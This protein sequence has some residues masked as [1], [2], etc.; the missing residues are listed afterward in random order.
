[1]VLLCCLCSFAAGGGGSD[2]PVIV[3]QVLAAVDAMPLLRSDVD[4]ILMLDLLSPEEG[5]SHDELVA[6]A[7]QHRINLELGYRELERSGVLYRL[8]QDVDGVVQ[9]MTAAITASGN[10]ETKLSAK[11]LSWEDVRVLAVRIAAVNAFIDE[12][13]RSQITVTQPE[14]EQEYQRLVRETAGDPGS[15]PEQREQLSRLLV[16]RKLNA[17]IERWLA[18]AQE[19]HE[20][21]RFA[22]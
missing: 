19:N 11:G 4:L 3:D 18:A 12:R 20:V 2:E 6:R 22:R 13:L 5:E 14:L 7:L 8:T 17:E 15:L 21:T 10:A 1:V 9:Q 16:E